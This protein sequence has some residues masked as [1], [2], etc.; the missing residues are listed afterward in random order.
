[1]GGPR[2]CKCH[3][4]YCSRS[5]ELALASLTYKFE[6]VPKMRFEKLIGADVQYTLISFNRGID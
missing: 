4:R 1:V 2:N 6:P 5:D 3:R